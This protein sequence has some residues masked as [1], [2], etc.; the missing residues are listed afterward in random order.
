M[1]KLLFCFGMRK[2][3]RDWVSQEEEEKEKGS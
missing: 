2:G 1:I 3:L